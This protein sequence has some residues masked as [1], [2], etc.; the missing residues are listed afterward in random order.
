MPAKAN[1]VVTAGLYILGDKMIDMLRMLVKQANGF[2]AKMRVYHPKSKKYDYCICGQD[3]IGR[4]VKM[5][6]TAE[7]LYDELLK[8]LTNYF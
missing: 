5:G 8:T 7:W 1:I 4:Q 3:T 2:G 6:G